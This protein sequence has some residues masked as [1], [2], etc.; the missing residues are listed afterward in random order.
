MYASS[1]RQLLEAENPNAKQQVLNEFVAK[2]RD[3]VPGSSEFIGGFWDI[4]FTDWNTRSRQL[5]RYLLRRLDMH[6]RVGVVPDYDSFTIE[7]LA[8]QH[9]A[10]QRTVSIDC[11]GQLGNLLFVSAELNERL[12]NRDPVDK[13]KIL[14]SEDVP[15]DASFKSIK[16]WTDET[17]NARTVAL[18]GLFREE[19]FKV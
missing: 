13:I 5:V 4:S 14:L 12:K 18:A 2:L 3:R 6:L 11:V 9:P 16:K 10:G 7:H 17:V 1:A 15:L 8:P 19:I